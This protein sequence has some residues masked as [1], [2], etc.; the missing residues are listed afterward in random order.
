M[1]TRFVY[2][3]GCNCNCVTISRLDTPIEVI[4]YPNVDVFQIFLR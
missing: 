2:R 3:K 1:L 4:T